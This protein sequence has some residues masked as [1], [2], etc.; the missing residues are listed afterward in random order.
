MK[1]IFC[2]YRNHRITFSVDDGTAMMRR[3]LVVAFLVVLAIVTLIILLTRVGR[4]MA[5]KDPSLNWK[6]NPHLKISDS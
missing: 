6:Y 5:E 4:E 1:I 3:Y 2:V